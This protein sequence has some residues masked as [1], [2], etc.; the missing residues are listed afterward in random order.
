M[1]ARYL[2]V[3]VSAL[4][5][6]GCM[7]TSTKTSDND[8]SSLSINYQYVDT[9][10]PGSILPPP[11]LSNYDVDAGGVY[12]ANP[13]VPYHDDMIMYKQY[14][15]RYITRLS[16]QMG[17]PGGPICPNRNFVMPI[18]PPRPMIKHIDKLKTQ[19]EIN[20]VLVQYSFEMHAWATEAFISIS[21]AINKHN[22]ECVY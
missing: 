10:T 21:K 4:F 2:V 1:K 22:L 16:E 18:I 8:G 6:A 9:K 3:M 19:G 11:D 17:T 12:Y 15:G 5:I 14:V 7:S 13:M 20:R